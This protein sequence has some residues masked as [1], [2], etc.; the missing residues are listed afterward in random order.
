MTR[1]SEVIRDPSFGFTGNSQTA[2]AELPSIYASQ[3]QRS[4]TSFSVSYN[5]PNASMYDWSV[6]PQVTDYGLPDTTIWN[7]ELNLPTQNDAPLGTFGS[8][9]AQ[10]TEVIGLNHDAQTA[11][12]TDTLIAGALLGIAGGVAIVAMQEVL[13]LIVGRQDELAE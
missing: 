12:S 3:T 8:Q 9:V 5:I 2:Y 13:H 1:E 4:F 7:Y 11:D 6:P 10:G